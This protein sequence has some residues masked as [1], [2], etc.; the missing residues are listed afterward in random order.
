M[1]DTRQEL[2]ERQLAEARARASGA[3]FRRALGLI[4]GAIVV[5]AIGSQRPADLPLA[6]VVAVLLIV[7]AIFIAWRGDGFR[8]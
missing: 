1:S 3:I 6:G 5:L 2:D 8:R 7:A 4:A